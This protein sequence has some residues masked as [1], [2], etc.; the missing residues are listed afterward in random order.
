MKS[1]GKWLGAEAEQDG[2]PVLIRARSAAIV[3]FGKPHL[4]V[5]D[6]G[7]DCVDDSELPTDDQ[8]EA[9]GAFETSALDRLE[10]AGNLV[11]VFIETVGGRVRYLAYL[12][13]VE[14]AV[15]FIDLHADPA[16]R[17]EFQST[18]DHEWRE[19]R[20]RLGSLIRPS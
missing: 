2:K 17:L 7:Y 14:E 4:V 9:V 5:I 6:L 16:L 18:E 1:S 19:Y 15:G 12:R 20:E 13:D 8:Y 11:L 10:E 3:D